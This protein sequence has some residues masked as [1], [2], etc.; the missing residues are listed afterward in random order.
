VSYAD[1]LRNIIGGEEQRQ[2]KESFVRDKKLREEVRQQELKR[3]E[4]EVRQRRAAAES[5]HR[6]IRVTVRDNRPS[7]IRVTFAT[8]SSQKA[9]ATPQDAISSLEKLFASLKSSFAYPT[10][11]E[12]S[13]PADPS[14]SQTIPPLAY[15]HNNI[16]V[17]AYENE[18]NKILTQLDAVESEGVLSIREA[19]KALVL[20]IE[21]E[22]N[23]LDRKKTAAWK[24]I[25]PDF[26][27]AAV[28]S[29]P[30]VVDVPMT[31]AVEGEPEASQAIP[32]VSE[33]APYVVEE[34]SAPIRIPI[35]VEEPASS[36]SVSDTIS[37]E[38]HDQTT[39]VPHD[40]GVVVHID[41]DQD[42]AIEVDVVSS[43]SDV[44]DHGSDA[45]SPIEVEHEKRDED[46]EMV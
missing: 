42:D 12:F 26:V 33:P 28:P 3:R 27:A 7:G 29:T 37:D 34:P 4:E 41:I 14:S 21:E 46:F 16:A 13:T 6:P 44:S 30:E 32:V 11:V 24:E 31:V 5:S 8:K 17:H 36:P 25:H 38:S 9:P 2:Q 43:E 22:L 45:D 15:S 35:Q 20:K 18:L 23:E 19:R 10:H 1:L 40:D 39:P